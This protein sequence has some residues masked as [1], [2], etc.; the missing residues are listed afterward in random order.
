MGCELTEVQAAVGMSRKWD[1]RDAGREVARNTIKQLETPPDFFLL[2]STIHY[3]DHGGF[4]EFLKGIYD[5]L[6]KGTPLVGGTVAGFI[7]ND[8]CYARGTTALA[9]SYPNMDIAIGI[10]HN[11]KRNPK[12]AVAKSCNMIKDKLI[13]SKY[14]NK[15]LLNFVSGP[16]T[17]KIPGQGN[18][19]VIDSGFMS[20]FIVSAFGMSQYIFQKGLG[21]ED[22]ILEES[23]KNLPDYRMLLGASIDDHKGLI[24]FQFFNDKIFTNALVNLGIATDLIFDICT[25]H[26]MKKTDTKFNITKLHKNQHIIQKINNKPALDELLHLLNW[27]EGY[28]NDKTMSHTAIYYPISLNRHGKDTP[29]VMPFVL[30]DSIMTPCIIDKG[31]VTILTVNGNN[32]VNAIKD[33]LISFEKIQPEFGLFS[34]CMTIME[35]LGDKIYIIKE[36]I[37]SIFKEKPFLMVFCAGEG[38]YSP[39]KKLTYANMSFNTSIFGYTK[40]STTS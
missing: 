23:S 18:K 12:K 31:E 40:Y 1:A 15:F 3:K 10:G 14:N 39:E 8:G 35:T 30:K 25:T 32:I 20:K 19:R 6:P 27:P 4:E 38:S 5:V 16:S 37:S 11:T 7:N 21:R 13:N 9:V 2:F 28:L 36:E 33:N 29:A 22:E 34:S 24:N 26:G 17:I